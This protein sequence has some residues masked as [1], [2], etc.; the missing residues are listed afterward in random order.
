MWL[1]QSDSNLYVLVFLSICNR[2]NISNKARPSDFD[3][4]LLPNSSTQR[5]ET[6]VLARKKVRVYEKNHAKTTN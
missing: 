1:P 3:A 2:V 4:V 6:E 5:L